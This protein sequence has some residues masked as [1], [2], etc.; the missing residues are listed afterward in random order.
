M[1]LYN[2]GRITPI[3]P[4]TT[5]PASGINEAFSSVSTNIGAGKVVVP[6]EPSSLFNVCR[7]PIL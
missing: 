1:Q 4:L 3:S 6:Y 2:E 5:K 7:P